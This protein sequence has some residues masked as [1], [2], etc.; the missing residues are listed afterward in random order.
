MTER[1]YIMISTYKGF[2]IVD[3]ERTKKPRYVGY[4]SGRVIIQTQIAVLGLL[5][6]SLHESTI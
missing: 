2:E 6:K 4:S 5:L 1:D 3:Y